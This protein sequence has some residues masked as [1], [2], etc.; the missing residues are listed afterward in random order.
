MSLAE[1]DRVLEVWKVR[2]AGAAEALLGVQEDAT[3]SSLTGTGTGSKVQLSG[4][5]AHEAEI[6]LR[7]I[8]ALFEQFG[9]LQATIDRA[10]VLRRELPGIFGAETRARELQHILFGRSILLTG[11][12][13]AGD[14]KTLLGQAAV[15]QPFTPDE[16]LHMMQSG[17]ATAHGTL[18]AIERAWSAG[19]EKLAELERRVAGLRANRAL[20]ST[21]LA[22]ELE[23]LERKLALLRADVSSD[24]LGAG[25]SLSTQIEAAIFRISERLDRSARLR[26]QILSAS[27]Q[28]REVR[29]VRAHSERAVTRMLQK[30]GPAFLIPTVTP[31]STVEDLGSW[32]VRI[33]QAADSGAVDKAA[34]DLR[35]WSLSASRCVQ[36]D[37]IAAS[38][39]DSRVRR[40]DELCG[41]AE[42]LIAK[43]AAKNLLHGPQSLEFVTRAEN[44]LCVHP[45]DLEGAETVLTGFAKLLRGAQQGST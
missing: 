43:A 20:P 3:Y 15:V 17:F 12:S 11:A 39:A 9:V 16:L 5:T 10:E 42:A 35:Q 31:E 40:C 6:A 18:L 19:A 2:L 37:R 34:Q 25:T 7:T 23:D 28:L 26:E 36:Q 38:V 13:T 44:A 27:E 1:V 4:L 33:E 30:L 41:R 45:V 22:A 14:R 21:V 8:R 29:T 24:P 32:L